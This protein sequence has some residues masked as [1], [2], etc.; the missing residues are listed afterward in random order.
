[1]LRTR[2]L[3]EIYDEV[4]RYKDETGSLPESLDNLLYYD[5]EKHGIYFRSKRLGGSLN[6]MSPHLPDDEIKGNGINRIFHYEVTNNE[7]VIYVLGSDG[8][9]GGGDDY[10]Y[11]PRKSLLPSLSY[12][13]GSEFFLRT[14][15]FGVPWTFAI[16]VCLYHMWKKRKD[17]GPSVAA[18]I[19]FSVMLVVF[20]CIAAFGII[21]LHVYP[22]H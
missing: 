2:F 20:E 5:A 10:Y 14:L 1:M 15:A 19:V 22:R 3:R 11:P 7:P 13:V 18:A 6:Y 16:S 9:E 12:F 21:A 8:K 17:A 4:M